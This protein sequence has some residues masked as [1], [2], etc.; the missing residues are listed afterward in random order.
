MKDA[1]PK[2]IQLAARVLNVFETLREVKQAM[3][4]QGDSSKIELT[5]KQIQELADRWLKETLELEKEN[6]LSVERTLQEI[7]DHAD[8]MSLAKGDVLEQLACSDFSSVEHIA[9]DLTKE[10]LK[11]DS[12][13]Q[14][15]P[16][17]FQKLCDALVRNQV[18][19]LEE[20]ERLIL[21]PRNEWPI[22]EN[23]PSQ[24]SSTINSNPLSPSQDAPTEDTLQKGLYLSEAID[25][26]VQ[27]K[28]EV[29]SKGS[30]KDIPGQLYQFLE[31][32]GDKPLK[33]LT[34]QDIRDYRDT[35]R[36][37]PT[38]WKSRKEYKNK[39]FAEI[40]E[41][42]VPEEIR[43]Q[44]KTLDTR[45]TN[46]RSFFNWAESEN[47]IDDSRIKT[48]LSVSTFKGGKKGGKIKSQ[49][50][51]FTDDELKKL[52]NAEEY[53]QDTHKKSWHF[54][55]PVLGL[56]TGARLEE[57][58]QLTLDDIRLSD[59]NVW[60]LDINPGDDGDKDI[61]TEA[62]IRQ[63][64]I[65]PFLLDDL[66]LVRRVEYLKDKDKTNRL[67]PELK[68]RSSTGK[69]SDAASGWFTR[70][71]RKCGVG[72]ADGAYSNVVFHSFRHYFITQCK[73]KQ[74]DQRM[75]A[76][77]VGH[78]S[79]LQNVTFDTYAPHYS[80]SIRLEEVIKK[81]DFQVTI[82]LKHLKESKWLVK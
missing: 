15:E 2:V 24:L 25:R 65:H 32:V 30:F 48:P 11:L 7:E 63:V 8:S 38:R 20:A 18:K 12:S 60:C 37:L 77:T 71:R 55:L 50:R 39:T 41:M 26:Y 66:G 80:P 68:L 54:W 9:D 42:D 82:G 22:Q 35:L 46:V 17:S 27:E 57:L 23:I 64:P 16:Y 58:C 61:K 52:F 62:G 74:L 5:E 43:P 13:D 70:F 28:S 59:D 75:I 29:W 19:F 67:F 81:L 49:R 56:F 45:F 14:L 73:M 10:K 36:K 34:S 3:E 1:R 44:R 69:W 51:A 33:A 6:R 78:E 40:L 4:S 53:A 76:E 47:Y 72:A 21:R 31:I 79:E